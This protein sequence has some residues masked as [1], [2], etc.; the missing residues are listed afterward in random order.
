MLNTK[1]FW[2]ELWPSATEAM[3]A[4]CAATA[5]DACRAQN[6]NTPRRVRHFLVHLSHES[7]GGTLF[8]ENMRYK[9]KRIMEVFGKGKHS[10]GITWPEAAA[11]AGKADAL[12]ERVYGLGNPRKARGLGN[13]E[14]GDG[15]KH[16]GTGGIQTTGKG[17]HLL[18]AS[19][20]GTSSATVVEDLQAPERMLILA[21]AHYAMHSF[22]KHGINAWADQNNLRNTTRALNGGYNG[23]D[24]RQGWL[25]KVERLAPDHALVEFCGLLTG[26]GSVNPTAPTVSITV[27]PAPAPGELRHGSTG[28]E[29]E[30]LQRKL[31]EIGYTVGA[32]GPDFG[33]FT[34]A[35]VLAFQADHGM[36]TT[37]VVDAATAAAINHAVEI[38][39]RRP[40]VEARTNVTEAELAAKGSR[41]VQTG[42][43]GRLFGKIVASVGV[44]VGSEQ[45]GTLEWLQGISTKL[46]QLKA[47]VDVI[48]DFAAYAVSNLS[49]ILALAGVVMILVC[50]SIITYRLDDHR[51]GQNAGR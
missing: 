31:V 43:F 37:G 38:G 14:P 16:R 48:R 4:G 29:V 27:E 11:L 28:F 12:A 19:M 5:V 15:A 33:D 3:I 6:I 18:L 21:A 39:E 50:G 17:A 36:P 49:V 46:P 32:I 35:A 22:N 30:A 45:F 9:A 40:M 13:T 20:C 42:M 51:S 34:R 47:V 41:T 23:L 7:Q 1:T 26:D 44:L 2:R 8:R 25:K 10:A 24:D